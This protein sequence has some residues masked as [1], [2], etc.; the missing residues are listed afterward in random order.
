MAIV[1]LVVI[2][3]AVLGSVLGSRK[4]EDAAV[5]AA[6]GIIT[7]P[8]TITTITTNGGVI[9]SD[10]VTTRDTTMSASRTSATEPPKPTTSIGT[11]FTGTLPT[12][13]KW[14]RIFNDDDKIRKVL[15][16]SSSATGID[17]V[18]IAS[19]S[20]KLN[21]HWQFIVA[22]DSGEALDGRNY[23]ISNLAIGSYYLTADEVVEGQNRSTVRLGLARANTDSMWLFTEAYTD[24]EKKA[25]LG[26]VMVAGALGWDGEKKA[27]MQ[28]GGYRQ[29]YLEEVGMVSGV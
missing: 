7:T 25:L 14:Y 12:E 1:I 17:Q 3:G 22:G 5:E 16:V 23:W 20:S 6:G 29:W 2:V 28:F 18:R 15:T 9:T 10:L 26:N 24:K 8:S 19:P 11:V 13:G 21:E 4:K 27:E